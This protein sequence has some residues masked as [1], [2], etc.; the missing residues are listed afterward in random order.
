MTTQTDMN[1]CTK[2]NIFKH[3]N[4][5]KNYNK[6]LKVETMKVKHP[7]DNTNRHAEFLEKSI[8]CFY[9]LIIFDEVQ[10]S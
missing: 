5:D 10:I 1:S 9:F 8:I 2:S 3:S 4:D 6:K 7:N